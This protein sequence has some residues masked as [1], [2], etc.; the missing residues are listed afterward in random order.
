MSRPKLTYRSC[1]RAKLLVCDKRSTLVDIFFINDVRFLLYCYKELYAR[2]LCNTS[3][4]CVRKR[5]N[6]AQANESK[7]FNRL[8]VA[9]IRRDVALSSSEIS[10]HRSKISPSVLCKVAQAVLS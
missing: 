1:T 7:L 10:E 5:S 6:I 9:H 4:T 3:R 8:Y 2:V